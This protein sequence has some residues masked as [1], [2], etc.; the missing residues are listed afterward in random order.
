M[1]ALIMFRDWDPWYKPPFYNEVSWREHNKTGYVSKSGWVVYPHRRSL[2]MDRLEIIEQRS[3]TV[4]PRS[5]MSN[6]D[7]VG[8]VSVVVTRIV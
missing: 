3:H 6:P 5:F 1:S 4:V 7:D 8:D 2:R